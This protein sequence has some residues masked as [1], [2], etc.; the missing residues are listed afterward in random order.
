MFPWDPELECDERKAKHKAVQDMDVLLF[1]GVQEQSDRRVTSGSEQG[2]D[3]H[4]V[5]FALGQWAPGVLIASHH[6]R[7]V[8]GVGWCGLS[9][10]IQMRCYNAG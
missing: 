5:V 6:E 10:T 9:T 3:L 7:E 2:S 4:R 1:G 8:V